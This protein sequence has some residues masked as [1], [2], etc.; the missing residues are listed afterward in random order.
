MNTLDRI[1]EE[2]KEM[3]LEGGFFYKPEN[4]F[5]V[6]GFT[7]SAG[8]ALVTMDK[9]YLITDFR[10][11]SQVGEQCPDFELKEISTQISFGQ[12]LSELGLKKVGFEDDFMT[13]EDM[14]VL[15]SKFSGEL[16]PMKRFIEEIRQ[17]KRE[18]EIE[19]VRKAQNIADDTFS[20]MLDF[21][22][23][24]MTEREVHLEL[25]NQMTR[26]GADGESFTAIVASGERGALPHGRASDKVIEK[27]DFLTLDFGCIYKGYCSDMTRTISV[28]KASDELKEIYEIVLRAQKAALEAIK[29]GA[30]CSDIDGV[31]RGIIS[32][33]GYGDNFGHGL[34]HS[35]GLEVHENPRFNQVD[36]SILKP[37]M[38]MTDEPG[39][40]IP[41]LGG[42]RIEDLVLVTEDGYEVL[43]KSD[44]E[45][46]ELEF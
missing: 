4:R 2:L 31:A 46:I 5:Y 32:E 33:A 27:G 11:F 10:Y 16:V 44:K 45:L 12:V 29:P 8:Y 13:I 19:L 22:K 34:G 26:R 35:I 24:G 43:S 18:D 17:I 39:I 36:N 30:V 41:G 3:G 42:V 37:G 40:Y 23:P 9:A 15:K 25:V 28:G 38:I 1:R 14:E 6:S 20:Y 21:I 7:G